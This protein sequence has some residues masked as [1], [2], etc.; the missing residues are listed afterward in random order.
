MY[1]SAPAIARSAKL[2]SV[3]KYFLAASASAREK[4][5]NL[6]HL[7][8]VRIHGCNGNESARN[9]AATN[10]TN[11]TIDNVSIQDSVPIF[12]Y[13]SAELKQKRVLL[14]TRFAEI[15]LR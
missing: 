10:A 7:R 5:A 15:F 6:I 12:Y 14:G 2:S 8:S 9:P 1:V 13:R 3:K 11:N 4:N